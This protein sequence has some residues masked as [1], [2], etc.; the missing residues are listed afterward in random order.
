[1]KTLF[2]D[3]TWGAPKQAVWLLL[4]IAFIVFLLWRTLRFAK[5]VR[6][7]TMSKYGHLVR[8]ASL[9]RQLI[10][11]FIFIVAI[12]ALLLALL[13]PQGGRVE[14]KI[15]REGRDLFIVL[16]ISKSMLASDV[17]PD[18]LTFAKYKIRQMVNLFQAERV[19]LILFSG[20]AFVQCPLTLDY[21]AFNL[22]LDQVSVETISSGSTSID[23]AL[24]IVL[25]AFERSPTR[26]HKLSIVFTD[27]EDFSADLLVLKQQAAKAGLHLFALG[28]GSIEGAPIPLY[29]GSEKRIGYQKDDQGAIVISRLNEGLLRSLTHDL[30]GFYVRA[31]EDSSDIEV[32]KKKIAHFEK[33]KFDELDQTRLQELYPYFLLISF[34]CLIIEWLL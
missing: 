18:R 7:L 34:I 16:D 8:N 33:E 28:I 11:V 31:V 26:K 4:I 17:K 14:E 12:F 5:V 19:G 10:K 27:G 15:V 30:G 20:A 23:Q 22:Y 32:L 29:D 2:F 25:D 3:F 9:F 13:R 6:L 24:K 21:D 1:M